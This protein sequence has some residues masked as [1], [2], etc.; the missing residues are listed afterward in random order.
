MGVLT[1]NFTT[2][3][4]EQALELAQNK[5]VQKAA[6]FLVGGVLLFIGGRKIY[7]YIKQKKAENEAKH[8]AENAQKVLKAA[9]IESSLTEAQAQSYANTLLNAFDRMGTD[10]DAVREVLSNIKTKGD[11]Y[12]VKKCFGTPEYGTYGKPM[13]GS[14]TPMN[15]TEWARKELSGDLL[16]KM[17]NFDTQILSSNLKGVTTQKDEPF[18]IL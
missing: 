15:L 1:Q 10:T 17:V 9:G 4:K 3:N 18:V 2:M 8:A 6:L 5:T 12:M 14:G 11:Y 7:N 16:D 13:W